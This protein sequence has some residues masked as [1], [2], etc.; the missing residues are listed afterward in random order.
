M[1]LCPHGL[2]GI[3]KN[4]EAVDHVIAKCAGHQGRAVTYVRKQSVDI[5]LRRR[6]LGLQCVVHGER[7]R[8]VK[9][10]V[11][12]EHARDHQ[13]KR[14]IQ[15][16]RIATD[17]GER[18]GFLFQLR[19]RTHQL[20]RRFPIAVVALNPAERGEFAGAV[21]RVVKLLPEACPQVVIRYQEIAL[22]N[23]VGVPDI[24]GQV[25]QQRPNLRAFAEMLLA[26]IRHPL[27]AL[28]GIPPRPQQQKEEQ[29]GGGEVTTADAVEPQSGEKSDNVP[30][31]QGGRG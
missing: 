5:P 28:L 9:V 19:E 23:A 8:G 30:G 16:F 24:I 15:F 29:H 22:E 25:A 14:G 2:F 10:G 26:L 13:R 20:L 6:L 27:H 18:R 21:E 31:A 1:R 17:I 3:A 4:P 11:G 12:G 7:G